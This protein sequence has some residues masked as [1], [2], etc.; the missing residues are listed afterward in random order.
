MT[1]PSYLQRRLWVLTRRILRT[2]AR[3]VQRDF[4]R[5]L[6]KVVANRPDAPRDLEARVYSYCGAQNVLEQIVSMRSFL[7]GVGAPQKFV[8]VS[9]GT[10]TATHKDHLTAH[11]PC[12]ECRELEELDV[13]PWVAALVEEKMAG[14]YLARKLQLLVAI[15]GGVEPAI[16]TD[17]DVLY[18]AA[19]D[20]SPLGGFAGK[21]WFLRDCVPSLDARLLT[22][23]GG[24]EASVLAPVNSGFCLF[25]CG[26]EWEEALEPLHSFQGAPQHFSEQTIV[27]NVMHFNGAHPLP[28]DRFLLTIEDRHVRSDLAVS[29]AIVLRHYVRTVRHKMWLRDPATY[30]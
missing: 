29:G 14:F 27:H 6:D 28:S 18:F 11:H 24:S 2:R 7:R 30:S 21:S 3:R 8:V 20:V 1:S 23:Q 4:A 9:D 13:P 25:G 15:S 17:S 22:S 19:P 12:V 16:Y 10:L 26:W 5:R